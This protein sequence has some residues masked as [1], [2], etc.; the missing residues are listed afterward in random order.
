VK[1]RQSIALVVRWGVERWIDVEEARKKCIEVRVM[2]TGG[3]GLSVAWLECDGR[4]V[5]EIE[6]LGGEGLGQHNTTS[7]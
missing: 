1:R 6:G 4:D 7:E 5:K 3:T 2:I